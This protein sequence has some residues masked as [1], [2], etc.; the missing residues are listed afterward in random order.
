MYVLRL[1]PLL[2]LTLAPGGTLS[3]GNRGAGCGVCI[4]RIDPNS[5]RS[6]KSRK[7]PLLLERRLG[8]WREE[9][10]DGGGG[11]RPWWSPGIVNA[12]S[13]FDLK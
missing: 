13:F 1:C 12:G 9:W 11:A 5:I 10:E 2:S 4:E 3:Q 7:L 6:E 8:V